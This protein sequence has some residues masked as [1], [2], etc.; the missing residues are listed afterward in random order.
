MF[1]KKGSDRA[2][3]EIISME[4]CLILTGFCIWE[5]QL[6]T[7]LV[8]SLNCNEE[9]GERAYEDKVQILLKE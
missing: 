8:Y 4:V 2:Q 7:Q 3:R 1:F 9:R 5:I 6:T